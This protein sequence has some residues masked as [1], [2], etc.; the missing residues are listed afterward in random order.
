MDFVI[1]VIHDLF[2]INGEPHNGEILKIK[3][4]LIFFWYDKGLLADMVNAFCLGCSQ[5]FLC[6]LEKRISRD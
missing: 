5:D 3:T 2:N 4:P 6:K 1:K